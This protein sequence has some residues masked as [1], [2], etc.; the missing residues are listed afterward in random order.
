MVSD[1][2]PNQKW[3]EIVRQGVCVLP[4]EWISSQV[5]KCTLPPYNASLFVYYKRLIYRHLYYSYQK[6]ELCPNNSSFLFPQLDYKLDL[7]NLPIFGF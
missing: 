5:E 2:R 3:I 4:F 7:D 6:K 1:G